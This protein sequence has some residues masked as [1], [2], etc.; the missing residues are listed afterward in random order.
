MNSDDVL[1][2]LADHAHLSGTSWRSRLIVFGLVIDVILAWYSWTELKYFH[3]KEVTATFTIVGQSE[4]YSRRLGHR[5]LHRLRYV[6]F[7]SASGQRCQQTVDIAPKLVPMGQTIQVQWLP[8]EMSESRLA[9]QSKEWVIPIFVS[10][11]SIFLLFAGLFLRRISQE[12]NAQPLTRQQRWIQQSRL[13]M[14][15]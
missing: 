1:L 2:S 6:F 3:A 10:Y 13:L 7:D 11:N 8:R 5:V 15:R 4:Y 9:I 12:T 14:P